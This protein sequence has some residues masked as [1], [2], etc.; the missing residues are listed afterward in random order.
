[1]A[2]ADRLTIKR[3]QRVVYSDIPTNMTKNEFTGYLAANE[4]EVAVREAFRNYMLT[5]HGERFFDSN[6]GGNV[7]AYLF[8]NVTP[9]MLETIKF[10]IQNAVVGRVEIISVQIPH[11]AI[12]LN[13][14]DSTVQNELDNNTLSVKIIFRVKNL[15][16]EQSVDINVRRIR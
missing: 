7:T 1:M 10:D 15:P 13:V 12:G 14:G 2:R 11:L 4:N 16:D 9:E 6:K 3:R 8:E 5:N